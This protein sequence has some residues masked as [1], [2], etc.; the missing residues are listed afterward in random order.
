MAV[1]VGC[2]LKVLLVPES[3]RNLE[4]TIFIAKPGLRAKL[5]ATHKSV[6]TSGLR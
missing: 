3:R 1:T 6:M 2:S 5:Q 4:F